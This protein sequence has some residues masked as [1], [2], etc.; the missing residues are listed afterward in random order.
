LIQSTLALD[1]SSSPSLGRWRISGSVSLVNPLGLA[2]EFSVSSGSN[3]DRPAESRRALT[4]TVRYSVPFGYHRINAVSSVSRSG[5]EVEGT[6]VKFLSTGYDKDEQIEWQWQLWRQGG[7]RMTSEIA[8]GRRR[9]VSHIEDVELI[10]Q[11]RNANTETFGVSL[12]WR[13]DSFSIFANLNEIKTFRRLGPD[14]VAFREGEPDKAVG[15]RVSGQLIK[16]LNTGGN[17]WQFTAQW[18]VLE[19]TNPTPLSDVMA[20]GGRY[21][22][23]GYTGDHTVVSSDGALVRN[24]IQLPSLSWPSS[25]CRVL[26]Y[27]GFDFGKVWGANAPVDGRFVSGSAVGAR[28]KYKKWS[29]DLALGVPVVGLRG[30]SR[31][32]V[33]PYLSANAALY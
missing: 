32:S 30:Y 31:P 25:D 16:S 2:D 6:T 11:R 13:S 19:T 20:L 8:K 22:V 17:V 21:S 18:D 12:E 4:N 10:V 24:E 33:V 3:L 26:P 28:I 5:Q 23:R 7:F 29:W 27:F 15:R 1:N 14:E 9:G